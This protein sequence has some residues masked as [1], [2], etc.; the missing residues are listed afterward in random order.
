MLAVRGMCG[1]RVGQKSSHDELWVKQKAMSVGVSCDH[2]KY[3]R[4]YSV[5]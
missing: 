4:E 3:C 2:C 5:G 1:L